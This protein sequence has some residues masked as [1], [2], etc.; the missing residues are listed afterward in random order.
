MSNKNNIIKQ[1]SALLGLNVDLEQMK[2]IDG[3]TVI[4]ADVFESGAGV[5]VVTEQGNVPVPVGDYELES[6]QILVVQEEGI[7]YEIKEVEA[8]EETETPT[9]QPEGD[10]KKDNMSEGPKTAKRTIESIVKETVFSRVEELA[11]ENETLRNEIVELKK[12]IELASQ[13]TVSTEVELSEQPAATPIVHNPENKE[14]APMMRY[15]T[16]RTR[17]TMDAVLEK[18]SK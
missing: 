9:E 1:I 17:T 12:S 5:F 11:S 4:E 14:A 16:K 3:A 6:G 8:T 13:K 18:L 10:L 7:I 15:A 2:L